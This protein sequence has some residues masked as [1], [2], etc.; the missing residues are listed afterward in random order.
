MSQPIVFVHGA[1]CGGWAF[2]AFRRPFEELGYETHAPNLPHHERGAD[3]EALAACG[4]KDYAHAIAQYAKNLAAPPILIGHSLGGLIVQMAAMHAPVA[5][6]A[7]LG[8]TPPWGVGATTMDEHA[9]AFG[10]ALLG[11]YW[12]RPVAP[13]YPIARRT[14][15]DR[16]SRE[17]A[18]KAFQHFA[19]E[20][21]R[22]LAE[23]VHWWLDPTMS[24]AAPVY[25]IQAPVLALAGGKDRVNPPSTVRRIVNR[26]PADQAT[27]QEFPAMS[28]WLM[29]EPEWLEVA[30][31]T[32]RWLEA[33][34]L[35]AKAAPAPKKRLKLYGLGP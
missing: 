26:F 11:D 6:L 17:D 28:H 2:D 23:A 30:N 9:N 27:F 8:P 7:L 12:R 29:G 34:G 20:S 16:L 3:L 35:T 18:R 13:D 24:G 15:L 25:R 14:T 32:L 10:V 33:R 19:P 21:G 5:A 4:V 31:A 1:F 22:A